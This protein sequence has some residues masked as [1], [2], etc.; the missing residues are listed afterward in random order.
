MAALLLPLTQATLPF[1]YNWSK[2]PAAWFGANDTHWESAAQ[3]DELGKYS[4]AIFGW[5]ALITA[6]NWTASIYAQMNQA[7][8]VKDKHPDLPVYVSLSC[9]RA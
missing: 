3:I 5:Q 1:P 9:R 2:F 7:A 8:I 6:T 4:M